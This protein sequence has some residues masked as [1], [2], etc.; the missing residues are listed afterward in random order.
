MLIIVLIITPLHSHLLIL[1]HTKKVYY[2]LSK[3]IRLPNHNF[4][5]CSPIEFDACSPP[6]QDCQMILRLSFQ[7]WN[8]VKISNGFGDIQLKVRKK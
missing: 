8:Q 6:Q 5:A 4:A 2:T 7:R 3:E 1:C